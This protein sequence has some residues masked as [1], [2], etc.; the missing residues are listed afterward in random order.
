MRLDEKYL[1]VLSRG[2]TAG[3]IEEAGRLRQE[4][5]GSELKVFQFVAQLYLRKEDSFVYE[6]AWQMDENGESPYDIYAK[7]KSVIAQLAGEPDLTRLELEI[8]EGMERHPDPRRPG[9]RYLRLLRAMHK[10]WSLKVLYDKRHQ[11]GIVEEVFL[12]MPDVQTPWV[13]LYGVPHEKRMAAMPK[14]LAKSRLHHRL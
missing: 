1:I 7:A 9:M 6:S 8:T 11:V 12:Q 10:G 4:N 5:P 2:P 13:T 14:E 3:Q